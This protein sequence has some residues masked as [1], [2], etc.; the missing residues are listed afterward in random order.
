MSTAATRLTYADLLAMPADGKRHEL[1]AGEH[2]VTPSPTLRHQLVLGHLYRDLSAFVEANGLGQVFFAPLDVVFSDFDVVE[3]DLL[4]VGRKR[5]ERLDRAC[6]RGA[7]D[8]VVEV[9]SPTTRR[10]DATAKL[11]LFERSGVAEYWMIDPDREWV[12][13][14]RAGP[15]GFREVARLV[16]ESGDGPLTSPLFQGFVLRLD[17]LFR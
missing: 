13:V 3:P 15:G 16:R 12:E 10:I 6:V 4:F 17:R 8:L 7:P 14:H 9:L 1:I 2:Y 11:R 5:Q